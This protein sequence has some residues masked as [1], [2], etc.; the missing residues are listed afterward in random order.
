[1]R[2]TTMILAAF[3]LGTAGAAGATTFTVAAA[4]NSS[5]FG[6]AVS[7]IVLH[8]G[9]TYSVTASV[10]D[11]W[12]AGA[13][14]RYSD[15]NGLIATRFATAADDSG[16]PVGTQIGASFVLYTQ[17]GFTAPYGALIGQIG[18]TYTLLG[19]NF[20]GTAAATGALDLLYWDVNNGD[21]FGTIAVNVTTVPEPAAWTL[22]IAGF[23]LVGVAARRRGRLAVA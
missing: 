5:S 16:Q 21:N 11:L 7:T 1:M 18:S 17:N 19:T 23:G 6:T 15:A 9:Q 20:H 10:N 13:L 2:S 8:A 12:S 3:A 4:G 22:M 14:P